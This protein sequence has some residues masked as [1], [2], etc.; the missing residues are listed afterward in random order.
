[1]LRGV[2][3][4][5]L[6]QLMFWLHLENTHGFGFGP[7]GCADRPGCSF[8]VQRA[9]AGDVRTGR[10]VHVLN[11]ELGR[12]KTKITKKVLIDKILWWILRG[13]H[14]TDLKIAPVVAAQQRQPLCMSA[15]RGLGH[16]FTHLLITAV[17]E[18]YLVDFIWIAYRYWRKRF[19]LWFKQ[20]SHAVIDSCL[21]QW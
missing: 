2:L 9:E 20:L 12:E 10:R 15:G 6:F 13:F 18:I 3:P 1:M 19:P 16:T 11:W 8:P 4:V 17:R 21:G 14:V 7:T 5:C